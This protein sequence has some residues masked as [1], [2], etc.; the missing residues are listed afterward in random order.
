MEIASTVTIHMA[1]SL[2]GFV[3]RRDGRVDWMEA[4]TDEF[5]EGVEL[6][7]AQIEAFLRS[8]DCY[9]LGSRTYETALK[10]DQQGLGW[11]YSDK[12]TFVLTRRELP[13]RR[14]SVEFHAGDLAEFIERRL[15]PAYRSIWF[16]GGGSVAG[17][18]LRRGLADEVRY[19]ILPIVLGEGLPFFAGLDRDMP[20]HLL[21]TKAYRSGTVALRYAVRKQ[22]AG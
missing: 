16:V 13:R 7:A 1:A 5:A 8:I 2:D 12:P 19:S 10:F 14:E 22:A 3:A 9:V 15:R 4:A 6:E 18:C 21:E 17:E 20:L 11:P